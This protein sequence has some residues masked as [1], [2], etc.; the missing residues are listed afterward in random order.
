MCISWFDSVYL[1]YKRSVGG[2]RLAWKCGDVDEGAWDKDDMRFLIAQC[3]WENAYRV[4][5]VLL[6]LKISSVYFC[7]IQVVHYTS[8]FCFLSDDYSCLCAKEWTGKWV[9]SMSFGCRGGQIILWLLG[10]VQC[11]QSV[12]SFTSFYHGN[13]NRIFPMK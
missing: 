8:F 11:D 1:N 4:G 5:E 7:H 13:F 6:R 12:P 9:V 2:S 10:S 3:L